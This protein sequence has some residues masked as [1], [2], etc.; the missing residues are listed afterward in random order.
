MS[1]SSDVA[2]HGRGVQ[3]AEDVTQMPPTAWWGNDSP[4]LGAL[5]PKQS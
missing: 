2:W 1:D 4:G 3:G 5:R